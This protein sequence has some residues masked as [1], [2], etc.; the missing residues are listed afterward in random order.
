MKNISDFLVIGSGLAGLFFALKASKFGKVILVT[1]DFIDNTNTS[2]AQGGIAS[3]M[4]FENDDFQKH[5]EDTMVAGDGLCNIDAVKTVVYNAPKV[6]NELIE[7]GVNFDKIDNEKYDLARE[8]GHSQH[9]ILHYKDVTGKEIERALVEKIKSNP[10]IEIKEY[11]FAID[12]ITQ[13]HLGAIVTRYYSDIKCFGAYVLDIK[14]NKIDTFLSKVTFLATG[15]LGNI[16][17]ITT[18]PTIATGDGIAMAYRA[19]AIVENME[20]VQFHPTALYEKNIRPSFLITEAMRGF[21]AIL[22]NHKNEDFMP[23][24]DERGSLA[25]R[26]IVARAI[27]NEL[28]TYGINHVWLDATATNHEALVAHFPNI[29]E[30]CLSL[31]IDIRKDFIPVSPAAHYL[32]GGVKIDLNART[33]IQYLYAAGETACSGLHGANRLASNSLL[34]AAVF[35]DIAANDAKDQIVKRTNLFTDLPEWDFKGSKYPEEMIL[36]TQEYK[37]L[38]QIMTN[39]VGV[40]RS[41][42]RLHRAMERLDILYKE[43]EELYRRSIPNVKIL[44]LRNA[45][46]T[47]YLVI[48]MA[49]QRRESRGLHYNLDYPHKFD[50]SILDK[51]L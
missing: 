50:Y 29:F 4:D 18:N 7:I 19:K 5:I 11:H 2:Y 34:E 40:V 9:R 39:Y 41:N 21:G 6:I 23:K 20:F 43:T 22:R 13:H 24:Y 48:K 45:I 51:I 16:Y 10:N 27:D 37:E 25:P 8:G 49:Q 14:N 33:N 17:D 44:E 31:G 35:A 28:K 32:C 12:L 30:K 42:L 46:N 26:D 38:Q 1:K 36:I 3:V 47:A 15:G